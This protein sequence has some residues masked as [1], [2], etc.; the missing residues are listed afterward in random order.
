MQRP[1]D[2]RGRGV[3]RDLEL[4]DLHLAVGEDVRLPRRGH[5]D[6]AR[7]GVGGLHLRRDGEVHVE[8]PFVPEVDVLDV[9]GADHRRRARR[10]D[11][12]E[13]AGDEVHLVARRAGDEEVGVA[14]AG[15]LDRAPA[16]AVRLDRADVEAVRERLEAVAYDVDH[17]QVVLRMERLDDGRSDLP[18]P[19]D[20]DLHGAGEP[21]PLACRRRRRRNVDATFRR[22]YGVAR[23]GTVGS[24]VARGGQRSAPSACSPRV[25]CCSSAR[26]RS[27]RRRRRRLAS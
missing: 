16:R 6:R 23:L 12:R 21:T 13:R 2:D 10:L 18:C 17:G 9:R 20:D 19:H 5:A 4:D 25:R 3:R 15:L 11:A 24:W 7:D 22:A 26:P 8:P 1:A 14:R 27:P